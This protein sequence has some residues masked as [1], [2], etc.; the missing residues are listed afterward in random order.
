MPSDSPADF[1]RP[2]PSWLIRVLIV[3]VVVVGVLSVKRILNGNADLSGNYAVWRENL[4]EPTQPGRHIDSKIRLRDPDP[5]PPI[6]YALY[7]PLAMLPLW[8]LATL[9]YVMNLACGLYLWRSMSRLLD[10]SLIDLS[11]ANLGADRHSSASSQVTTRSTPNTFPVQRENRRWIDTTWFANEP[12]ASQIRVLAA[13]A[14]LPSVIG[15]LLIGQNTFLL[16]TLVVS[17]YRTDVRGTAGAFKVG[18]LLALASVMKVL[19]VVFLLPF[20][21]R[22]NGRVLL[23]FVGTLCLLIFG[24]GSVFFGVEKNREFHVRWLRFA[25][26]GPESRPPDP[27]DPNTLRGSLRDKNQA[28]EAV[29]ARLTMD[30]P[31]RGRRS[32][33]PDDFFPP[34]INV[35]AV[36]AQTWRM[37]SSVFTLTCILI[38][39]VALIRSHF[40]N[41]QLSTNQIASHESLAMRDRCADVRLDSVLGQLAILSLTQM[42]I[43]PVLWSHYYL[44]VVFPLAYVLSEARH[45][46]SSGKWVFGIWLIALPGIGLELCRAVGLQLW[47][48]LMIYLWICWPAV[49]GM[50][51]PA[52]PEIDRGSVNF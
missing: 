10:E 22:R 43:S 42:F 19:P 28:V 44:W 20:V 46:R 2:V 51:F 40:A 31:I 15:A 36:E 35:I 27:K 47:V 50:F 11:A 9:W 8:L 52:V 33:E 7:A 39:V 14:V 18:A 17:A 23:G 5:Y 34:H 6:T 4:I 30:I 3:A 45:G 12:V 38:G 41:V 24:L 1:S 48:N 26:Q 21:I 32:D 16:M 37:M 49:R 29:I 25:T 13:V